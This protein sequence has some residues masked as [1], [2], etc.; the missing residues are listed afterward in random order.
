MQNKLY[1]F[2]GPPSFEEQDEIVIKHFVSLNG[3][4]AVCGSTTLKVFC[5]ITGEAAKLKPKSLVFG[6]PPEYEVSG[7]DFASEGILTLNAV[8]AD[9]KK[10]AK[11]P[12]LP[13]SN[14]ILSVDE[15]IF[16]TGDAQNKFY[17]A[18]FYK[19]TNVLP[20][21]EI[22]DKIVL[23]LKENGKTALKEKL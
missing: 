17:D 19:R 21:C 1:I 16:I 3:K 13:L 23:L 11:L 9:L 14:L 22:I 2:S 20:R 6:N 10:G 7:L 18:D 4:K 12:K 8:F 5:K 15:I